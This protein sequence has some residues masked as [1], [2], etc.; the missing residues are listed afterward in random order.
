MYKMLLSVCQNCAATLAFTIRLPTMRILIDISGLTI[1]LGVCIA[2]AGCTTSKYTSGNTD[3]F[4]LYQRL[5]YL[6]P[7]SEAYFTKHGVQPAVL[8]GQ[9]SIEGKGEAVVDAEVLTQFIESRVPDPGSRA[10]IVLDWE[11]E[12]MKVLNAGEGASPLKYQRYYR[13][14]TEA[15]R[16]VKEIRP[17]AT[18]GYYGFPIRD[19]W[20]RNASWRQKNRGLDT[21]ISQ[22]DAVFPSVY[23][24]YNNRLS[25]KS[26]SLYVADN[27]KEALLMGQR[28]GRPVYPFVWHRYHPSNKKVGRQLIPIPE[29]SDHLRN[30]VNTNINGQRV[31]GLFWWSNEYGKFIQGQRT[32]S[33]KKALKQ[34]FEQHIDQYIVDY[35]DAALQ[36]VKVKTDAKQ[37]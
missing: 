19:Y 34:N 5:N 23:D 28:I 22:F 18:V 16:L 1:T 4:V 20:N 24:F 8:V 37:E 11:G 26:D 14:F 32:E 15:Y 12:A 27:I 30:I 17:N 3:K 29:W 25:D 35:L 21:L 13:G 33:D 36:A 10:M 2:F 7:V 6:G 31:N 9:R